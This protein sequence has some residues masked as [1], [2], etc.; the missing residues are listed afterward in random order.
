MPENF[1]IFLACAPK[2][3]LKLSHVIKSIQD[4]IDGFHNLFI[5]SPTDIPSN[6]LERIEMMNYTY[7]D[8]NGLPGVARENW[9][10]RPNWCFQQH[11]KLFQKMTGRWYLTLDCDVIINRP[12][13][14]IEGG[15]P[16]YYRGMDQYYRPY[17]TFMDNMMGLEKVS[18]RSCIAD[19]NFINRDIIEDML[20]RYGYSIESFIKKSQSIT[21]RDCHI[22][23]PE[24]YGNYCKKYF[25]DVYVEKDLIQAPFIG[26]RQDT[27]EGTVYGEN[28]IVAAI[29][30]NKGKPYDVFSLHSWLNEGD[31]K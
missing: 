12:L 19:M 16:V 5:C 31:Q 1:D 8:Q 28:E 9:L 22:G 23:E 24:L 14:F 10:F 25:S 21:N 18:P 20:R 4:N 11:L 3:Y 7:L 13:K 15:K 17:F 30:A 27:V 6:I 26:R 2:D 29:E